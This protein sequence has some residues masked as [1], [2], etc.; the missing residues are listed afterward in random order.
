MFFV[1]LWAWYEV[2][3]VLS[4]VPTFALST[5]FSIP[6]LLLFAKHN[7]VSL[8]KPQPLLLSSASITIIILLPFCNQLV[9][10]N[11]PTSSVKLLIASVAFKNV[12][13]GGLESTP[14]VRLSVCI[15]TVSFI[16]LISISVTTSS[17]KL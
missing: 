1:V 4:T 14:I 6:V 5:Q 13:L 8:V 11:A 10:L 7:V 12:I 9:P 16:V 2:A 3:L 15:D 17:H